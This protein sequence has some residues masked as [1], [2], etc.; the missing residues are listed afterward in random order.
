MA[1]AVAAES[2]LLKDYID[3]NKNEDDP[4]IEQRVKFAEAE[5]TRRQMEYFK[6]AAQVRK[7]QLTTSE[8]PL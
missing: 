5:I 3:R 2:K 8:K 4:K 1:N 7:A 6:I